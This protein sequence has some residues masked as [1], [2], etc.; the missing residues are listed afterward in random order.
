MGK[1]GINNKT[2]DFFY[3]RGFNGIAVGF[4]Y[5]SLKVHDFK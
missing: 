4:L 5:M 3:C 2:E 1:I